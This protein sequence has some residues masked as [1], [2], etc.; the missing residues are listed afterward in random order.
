MVRVNGK[1]FKIYELDSLETFKSRLA[2]SM[3]TL[4]SFLYFPQSVDNSII[5][6]KNANI[7]VN[8]ILEEIKNSTDSLIQLINDIQAKIGKIKFDK[9]KD[10]VRIWLAYN[11][12]L[13]NDVKIQGKLPLDVIGDTLQKNK[14][15]ITSSQIHT[16][17]E[18]KQQTQ[19][20]YPRKNSPKH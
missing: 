1:K 2:S 4:D 13:K 7:I 11:T 12:T 20:I 5:R 17:L 6:D 19:K 14:I 16:R 9:G 15:Y 8:D 10:I 3:G 18:R